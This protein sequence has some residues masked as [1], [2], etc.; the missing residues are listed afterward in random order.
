MSI[1]AY[2]SEP[3]RTLKQLASDLEISGGALH[4]IISGRRKPSAKLTL[5]IERVT[6]LSRESIR[7][8][9]YPPAHQHASEQASAA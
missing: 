1:A 9:L 4:D 5:Q 8:D 3:G 7:P 6:G 2:L